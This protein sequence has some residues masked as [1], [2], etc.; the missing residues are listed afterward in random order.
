MSDAVDENTLTM[1]KEVME[2]DFG[3]LI[4]AYLDDCSRKMP[5]LPLLLE[6]RDFEQLRRMAHSLK[7]ASSNFGAHALTE[8]CL[9]IE[10]AAKAGEETGLEALVRAAGAE[11]QRVADALAAHR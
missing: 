10:L 7:G 9:Q 11:Q 6:S 4:D 8:L 2:D 1:L 5:Q 3:K